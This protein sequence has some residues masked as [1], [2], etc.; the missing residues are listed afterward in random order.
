MSRFDPQA[1]FALAYVRAVSVAAGYFVQESTRTFDN[2]GVD[3]TI[4]RRGQ[5][6]QTLSPR[7]DLQ[8]KSLG[9]SVERDPFHYDLEMKT[10]DELRATNLQVPRILLLVVVPLDRE[11]WVSHSENELALRRCGYWL[12][13]RGGPEVPNTSKRRVHIQR[14]NVFDI[15]N[16]QELMQR[17]AEGGAP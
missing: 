15:R 5:Q 10:Y 16:V 11:A 14:T 7:L 6:G 9:G 8:V 13:L 4:L 17:V 1:E 12:S 2:D 3:L